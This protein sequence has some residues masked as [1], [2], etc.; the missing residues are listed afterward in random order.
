MISHRNLTLLGWLVLLTTIFPVVGCRKQDSHAGMPIIAPD[1]SLTSEQYIAQGVPAADRTWNPLDFESAVKALS[2]LAAQN[3]SL[4]PRLGSSKSGQLF[5]G[6]AVT[7]NWGIVLNNTLPIDQRFPILMGYTDGINKLLKIYSAPSYRGE[8]FDAELVELIKRELDLLPVTFLLAE[9]FLASVPADDPKK[10]VRE[11]GLRKMVNGFTEMVDGALV[12]LTES[13]YFRASER[14]RLA[15]HLTVV[16]PSIFARL[17]R[18]TRMEM[19]GRIEKM[20]AV[21]QNAELKR[22]LQALAS[23][24]QSISPDHI[25]ALK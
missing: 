17:P 25:P 6:M 7:N 1:N 15:N 22:A 20:A 5:D 23:V 8:S 18:L 4:L 14:I 16:M 24:V 11:E 13:K 19:P 2:S 3:A 9:E 21:E 12:C 10:P